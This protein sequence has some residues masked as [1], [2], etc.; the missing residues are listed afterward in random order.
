M[1]CFGK[2][3]VVGGVVER[4]GEAIS[5]Q[6]RTFEQWLFFVVL[7]TSHRK[8]ATVDIYTPMSLHNGHINVSMYAAACVCVIF[9]GRE[10]V[11][12][13]GVAAEK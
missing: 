8:R 6:Y 13:C 1:F 2:W 4:D 5:P 10:R 7:Q 12:G 3:G 9:W 11:G